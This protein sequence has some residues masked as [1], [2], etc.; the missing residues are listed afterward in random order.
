M[1]A[2]R[3]RAE[4]DSIPK[5]LTES[6]KLTGD[7]DALKGAQAVAMDAK[8]KNLKS[9]SLDEATSMKQS[10]RAVGWHKVDVDRL[11]SSVDDRAQGGCH[12]Q[13]GSARRPTLSNVGIIPDPG[14]LGIYE[15][16][17]YAMVA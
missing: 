14:G 11:S 13:K 1:A 3:L 10:I 6:E 17:S 4:F 9:L 2:A 8:L 12:E 16:R 5:F 15:R 7:V